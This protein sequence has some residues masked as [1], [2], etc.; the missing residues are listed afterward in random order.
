MNDRYDDSN[1]LKEDFITYNNNHRD[2]SR[3]PT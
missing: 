2:T 1:N 3:T